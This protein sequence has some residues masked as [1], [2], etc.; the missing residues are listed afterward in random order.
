MEVPHHLLPSILLLRRHHHNQAEVGDLRK[1]TR[2]KAGF[3]M[4]RE[5]LDTTNH[6]RGYQSSHVPPRRANQWEDVQSRHRT[7]APVDFD[8]EGCCTE[9]GLRTPA[10]DRVP[11]VQAVEVP[12]QVAV[13]AE[14]L[15]HETVQRE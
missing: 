5:A 8:A 13:V 10:E 14:V 11:L 9:E 2:V 15:D 12:S 1:S 3:L 4:D 6:R 7:A